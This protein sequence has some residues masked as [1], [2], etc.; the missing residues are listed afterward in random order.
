MS[1]NNR[2]LV[3]PKVEESTVVFQDFVQVRKD[4]LKSQNGTHNY[5]TL[6]TKPRAVVIMGMTTD[7][8]WILNEE[9]RH[10]TGKVLLGFPGGFLNDNELPQDGAKRELLEETGYL[11]DTYEVLG[12]A[13]PYP[14]LSTQNT[15]YV[16][17][18]NAKKVADPALDP[19]EV[20]QNV[21]MNDDEIENAIKDGKSIDGT[22]LT[23]LGFVK[24][25]VR[26]NKNFK[27]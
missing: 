16:I 21:L 25:I 1:T 4:K 24:M 27:D 23:A 7:G 22:L 6:T 18:R 5:F 12:S 17:A 11:A 8:K 20:L 9:Y 15:F 3:L 2:S 14:G 19:D 10:P 26:K 13:Y